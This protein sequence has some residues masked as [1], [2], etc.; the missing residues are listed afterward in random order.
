MMTKGK[1]LGALLFLTCFVWPLGVDATDEIA[2]RLGKDCEFCH[3]DGEELNEVGQTFRK[4]LFP[5]RAAEAPAETS[6]WPKVLRLSIRYAHILCGFFWFGTIL[7]VH[8]VLKPQY[9]VGGLPRGEVLVGLASMVIMGVTGVILTAY[10]VPSPGA[11]MST[12]FG[13]FLS[14]KIALYAIMVM[15]G[16]FA[17][18]F[19]G[20]RLRRKT[21]KKAGELSG[22]MTHDELSACDGAEGSPACFAYEG[23]V[24]DVTGS[25][26]WKKGLHAGKHQAGTD[27]TGILAKAP[28]GDEVFA[29][30]RKVGALKSGGGGGA[31]WF[32]KAFFFIA[33]MNLGI[34]LLILLILA[35]W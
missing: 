3:S 1:A 9:A 8:I 18:F 13:V 16:M 22:D 2:E 28:H 33:Y 21:R 27:L 34:V 23:S 17:V 35:L 7:Y 12:R 30:V 11:M 31:P 6:A 15:S 4:V 20:P 10:R 32:V 26:M 14:V 29:S 25:R 19:I 24:Y 5:G